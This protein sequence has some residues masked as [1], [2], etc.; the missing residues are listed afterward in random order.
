MDYVTK[1]LSIAIQQAFPAEEYQDLLYINPNFNNNNAN[2]N[3]NNNNANNNFTLQKQ[4]TTIQHLTILP[5]PEKILEEEDELEFEEDEEKHDIA[6][7]INTVA[8]NQ[9]GQLLIATEEGGIN[10]NSNCKNE[11]DN[12]N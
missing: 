7:G 4:T 6:I 8:K 1:Y 5:F 11:L 10:D 2:N 9:K 3:A 12:I